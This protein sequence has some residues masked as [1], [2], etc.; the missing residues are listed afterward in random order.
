MIQLIGRYGRGPLV[1]HDIDVEIV[2]GTPPGGPRR[3]QVPGSLRSCASSPDA[4]HPPTV[5]SPAVPAKSGTSRT[6]SR[7]TP[8]APL[9][10]TY[11]TCSVS[12]QAVSAGNRCPDDLAAR[13]RSRTGGWRHRSPGWNRR[14]AR[15]SGARSRSS[16]RSPA[17][18]PGS[19]AGLRWPANSGWLRTR[20]ASACRCV[21]RHPCQ[22]RLRRPAEHPRR[23]CR[24]V[25]RADE[26]VEAATSHRL[27]RRCLWP[28]FR[29]AAAAFAT[30]R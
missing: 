7:P 18:L 19:A 3:Q 29:A 8:D 13:R 11:G 17:P 26:P 25:G 6:G 16:R 20:H 4:S 15:W 2:P 12:V 23:P 21:P 27:A 28:R 22:S 1:V 5:V 9:R 24:G 14:S 30:L 10:P